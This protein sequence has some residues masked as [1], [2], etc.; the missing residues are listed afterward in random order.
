MAQFRGSQGAAGNWV[1]GFWIANTATSPCALRSGVT[2][3]LANSQGD[4]RT[5]TAT[6]ETPIL[7]SPKST[8]PPFAQDPTK[9]ESLA[10]LSLAWLTVPNAVLQLGGTGTQCPQPVFQAESVRITFTGAEPLIVTD[11]TTS[12]PPPSGTIPPIC[13]SDV[14]V[15]AITSLTAPTLP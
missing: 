7:L 8:I 14:F 5:A 10:A 2:V 1:S 13:G 9:G 12:Q 6:I 4:T 15:W 11:L 3:V